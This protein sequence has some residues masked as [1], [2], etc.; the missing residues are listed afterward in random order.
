MPH[1]EG[2]CTNS[3]KY[4]TCKFVLHLRNVCQLLED[5]Q[6]LAGADCHVSKVVVTNRHHIPQFAV[7][8]GKL[9][10]GKI[11]E[12]GFKNG[13]MYTAIGTYLHRSA[14]WSVKPVCV[15][16]LFYCWKSQVVGM[17]GGLLYPQNNCSHDNYPK[18]LSALDKADIASNGVSSRIY[19]SVLCSKFMPVISTKP[20]CVYTHLIAPT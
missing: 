3:H 5:K 15:C 2:R 17:G 11:C 8:A 9:Q 4:R 20:G 14:A 13:Y 7:D 6:S 18:Q 10:V 19:S 1:I 16:F 12:R